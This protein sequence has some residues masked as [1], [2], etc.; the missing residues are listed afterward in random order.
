MYG[1]YEYRFDEADE[2]GSSSNLLKESSVRAQNDEYPPSTPVD[3]CCTLH[4][5][6]TA[7]QP[8]PM[9]FITSDSDCRKTI[10]NVK[11]VD[12]SRDLAGG[13]DTTAVVG[14]EKTGQTD[15]AAV[16]DA[17]HV[18]SEEKGNAS[19]QFDVSEAKWF[20][21]HSMVCKGQQN[22]DWSDL[23]SA[24][25]ALHSSNDS[26]SRSDK[27]WQSLASDDEEPELCNLLVNSS[28]EMTTSKT[29]DDY[30]KDMQEDD[31]CAC[32]DQ[33][34]DAQERKNFV[35]DENGAFE[36]V[37][38]SSSTYYFAC[39]GQDE[40]RGSFFIISFSYHCTYR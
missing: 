21:N 35:V 3:H 19:S 10:T 34:E 11:D 24:R 17:E 32:N 38:L 1:D 22:F 9:C 31:A 8:S 25:A 40:G 28:T 13:D 12:W 39:S 15:V 33:S 14:S 16:F 18:M 26:S 30:E 5:V 6:A 20:T 2:C 36:E 27:D 23:A 29:S 7:Y 4:E 37:C